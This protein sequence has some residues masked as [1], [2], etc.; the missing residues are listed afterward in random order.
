M[1]SVAK[2]SPR[3]RSWRGLLL[4]VALADAGIPENGVEVAGCPQVIHVAR[5]GEG[6]K[7][8]GLLEDGVGGCLVHWGKVERLWPHHLVGEWVAPL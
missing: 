8:K 6:D 5:A 1:G 4:P 2:E 3:R 7:G